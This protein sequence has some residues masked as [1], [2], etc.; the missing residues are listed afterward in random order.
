MTEPT[1]ARVDARM[2]RAS[3]LSQPDLVVMYRASKDFRDS[4]RKVLTAELESSIIA[5]EGQDIADSLPKLAHLAG[6]RQALRSVLK[7]LEDL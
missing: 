7:L 5:S 1:K 2:S 3:G 4:V 6:Q